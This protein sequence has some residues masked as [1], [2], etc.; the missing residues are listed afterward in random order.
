M[1]RRC[2]H[3]LLAA[4]LAVALALAG[5]SASAAT[6]EE[7]EAKIAACGKNMAAA[8]EMADSAR[9]LG[10]PEDHLIIREA[11]AKYASE[12]ALAK[13]LRLELEEARKPK[14]TQEDLDLLSRIIYAEAGC[15]WMPDWV[16][17]MVG[18]VVLN[19]VASDVYPNTI[20]EVIYQ[21]G[22]YGPA[23]NGSLMRTPD[24]RTIANARYLLE[25]GS[26][27]PANVTGQSGAITGGGLYSSYT[28]SV[29]GTTIYFCYT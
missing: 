17:R 22:Q 18:S 20:R 16:Q 19:R 9:F 15:T 8:H 11:Q 14:Y 13:R 23:T 10:Y 4:V 24:A 28:D 3:A 12:S 5:P 29:L 1:R 7:L 26:V 25:N 21:P 6:P 2:F 27:C